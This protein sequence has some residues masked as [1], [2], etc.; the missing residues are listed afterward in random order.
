[1][2]F[3]CETEIY[4]ET[5][6]VGIL[7]SWNLSFNTKSAMPWYEAERFCNLTNSHLV[8]IFNQTQQDFLVMRAYELE[9]ITAKNHEFCIGGHP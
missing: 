3:F 4:F 5:L 6:K 2:D 9:V 7:D 8:E 1:M